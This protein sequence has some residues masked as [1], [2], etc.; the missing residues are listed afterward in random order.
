[1][2]R[3]LFAVILMISCYTGISQ[4]VFDSAGYHRFYNGLY[5]AFRFDSCQRVKDLTMEEKLEGLSKVWYEAKF[6][7][8]NF[9]LVPLLNWDSIYR[10]FIPK[11]VAS[12]EIR[13]YYRV[14]R[15]F[16]QHLHDG[17]EFV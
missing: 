11:V 8:A 15:Q 6:N 12:G 14:L 2:K 7:F 13:E 9:D 16:N 4:Q 3:L 1:M 10:S 5:G 17:E